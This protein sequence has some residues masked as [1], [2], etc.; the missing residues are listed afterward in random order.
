MHNLRVRNSNHAKVNFH[1]NNENHSYLQA[2]F[3]MPC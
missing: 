2:H 1:K 3:K